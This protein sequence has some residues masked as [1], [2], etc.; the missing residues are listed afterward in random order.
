M[1]HPGNRL[2]AMAARVCSAKTMERL[3]D[4]V[5]GDM[6]TE[7][8]E[9]IRQGRVWRS[10]R[11]RVAG[12]AAFW[13]VMAVIVCEGSMHDRTADD[14]QALRRMI[15][16]SISGIVVATL[17]LTVLGFTGSR[18]WT[19]ATPVNQT[20][21]LL[22]LVPQALPIALPVGLLMG[23][24]Q[25][26]AARPISRRSQGTLLLMALVCSVAS[27]ATMAWLIPAGS[28]AYWGRIV[29]RD[30]FPNELPLGELRQRV[31]SYVATPMEGSNTA[32]NLRLTYHQRWALSG[33]ALV[34][35]LFALSVVPRGP[36]G[37]SFPFVAG[38]AV[39][40]GYYTVMWKARNLGMSGGVS[41]FIAAWLPNVVFVLG[42]AA[43]LAAVPRRSAAAV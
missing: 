33:A 24:L 32:R 27:F 40:F 25:G 42:A 22:F 2:R 11:V 35:A 6:Q 29:A 31:D 19:Q 3:I 37:R 21:F 15:G 13:K 12:Y 36:V 14:R 39:C 1:T 26:S 4:P 41:P 18:G 17:L 16:F 9:A 23:I 30:Q 34:F 10:R 28:Q 7:Y 8:A 5:V 43:L 38:F 20:R